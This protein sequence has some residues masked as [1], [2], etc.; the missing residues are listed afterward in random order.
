MS[1]KAGK[2][3]YNS[4]YN[5]PTWQNPDLGTKKQQPIST[6]PVNNNSKVP[7]LPS[8]FLYQAIQGYVVPLNAPLASI[9][10][11]A[12]P[13]GKMPA[14]NKKNTGLFRNKSSKKSG[15]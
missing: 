5:T 2:Q 4:Y 3:N 13:T 12:L 14:K 6:S 9:N 15:Y 8:T 11:A 1:K 10:K 7:V